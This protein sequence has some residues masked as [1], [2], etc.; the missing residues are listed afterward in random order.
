MPI[1]S[2]QTQSCCRWCF[3]MCGHC[4]AYSSLLCC[5]SCKAHANKAWQ[6]LGSSWVYRQSCAAVEK[7]IS[8]SR[9]MQTCKPR[10]MWLCTH[11]DQQ[12]G[13]TNV[14]KPWLTCASLASCCSPNSLYHCLHPLLLVNPALV[15][16]ILPFIWG[17]FF[18]FSVPL[19]S[20]ITGQILQISKMF[21]ISSSCWCNWHYADRRNTLEDISK[22]LQH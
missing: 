10:P 5:M 2:M 17:N 14:H 3:N 7:L 9:G 12:C 8:S 4:T 11:M 15:I 21:S 6:L 18:S 1:A 20:Q 13:P 19:I 16:I 22:S